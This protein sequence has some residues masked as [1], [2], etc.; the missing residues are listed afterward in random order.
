MKSYYT[1][2]EVTQMFA[3]DHRE[4]QLFEQRRA[5]LYKKSNG[6]GGRVSKKIAKPKPKQTNMMARPVNSESSGVVSDAESST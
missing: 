5:M 3:K 6:G 2:S 4:Q 1:S